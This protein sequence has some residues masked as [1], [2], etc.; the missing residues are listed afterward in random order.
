MRPEDQKE[1][2]PEGRGERLRIDASKVDVARL[3]LA[4]VD[5]MVFGAERKHAAEDHDRLVKETV[6]GLFGNG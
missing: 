2:L 6:M 5:R 4:A 1:D 3:R